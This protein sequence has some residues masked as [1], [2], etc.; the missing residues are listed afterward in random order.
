[1]ERGC[2]TAR[3]IDLNKGQRKRTW[4]QGEHDEGGGRRNQ[5]LGAVS[6]L[7]R[8]PSFSYGTSAFLTGLSFGP[9][10]RASLWGCVCAG[11]RSVA[12]YVRAVPSV[13][14]WRAAASVPPSAACFCLSGGS[15]AGADGKMSSLW[16]VGGGFAFDVPGCSHV[17]VGV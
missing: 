2:T 6:A 8:H 17:V 15:A 5:R 11:G 3:G 10:H 7:V 16:V 4:G 1:M 14:L 13:D 12:V 9:L